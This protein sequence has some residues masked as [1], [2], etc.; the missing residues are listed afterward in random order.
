MKHSRKWIVV[1]LVI[2]MLFAVSLTAS[3]KSGKKPEPEPE[4]KPAPEKVEKVTKEGGDLVKSILREIN[5]L[6]KLRERR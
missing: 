2:V 4:P 3:G 6:F 5:I 1:C